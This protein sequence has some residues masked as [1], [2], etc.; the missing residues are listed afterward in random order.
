MV[1]PRPLASGRH[2]TLGE[3]VLVNVFCQVDILKGFRYLDDAGKI[4]NKYDDDFP[5]KRVSPEGL[6]MINKGAVLSEVRVSPEQIWLGFAKPDSLQYVLDHAWPLVRDV[7]AIIEVVEA[8]RFGLRLEHLCPVSDAEAATR[9]AARTIF[10]DVLLPASA[11]PSFFEAMVETKAEDLEIAL[12][13]RPVRRVIK[14][15]E[16]DTLPDFAMMFDA[17]IHRG[18]EALPVADVRK[19][20]RACGSWVKSSLPPLAKRVMAEVKSG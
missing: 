16:P 9:S 5:E 13:V 20:L 18:G 7:A 6:H 19:F 4:M 12:R 8:R 3:L 14:P 1:Q 15:R 10:A 2:S 11:E 17:D